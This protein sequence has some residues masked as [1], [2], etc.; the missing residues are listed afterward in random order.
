MISKEQ[1][2]MKYS[3][4]RGF[5]FLLISIPVQPDAQYFHSDIPEDDSDILMDV[6]RISTQ[7]EWEDIDPI[8]NCLYNSDHR[9][10]LL[11]ILLVFV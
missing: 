9:A 5:H 2:D 3:A 10:L 11:W 1:D 6:D 8:G 4:S 7:K